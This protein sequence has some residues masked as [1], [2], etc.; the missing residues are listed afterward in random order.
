MKG[1]LEELRKVLELERAKKFSDTA[2]VGGLDAYLRRFLVQNRLPD[3]HELLR[4]VSVLPPRGY[5]SL[6]PIQRR[7]VVE[8][9]LKAID[10]PSPAGG[11]P[12]PRG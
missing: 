11:G 9:L 4:V 8:A 10:R 12:G 5:A 6:H 3:G 1:P 7:R 2:V